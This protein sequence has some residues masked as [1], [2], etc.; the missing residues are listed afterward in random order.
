MANNHEASILIVDDQS[1]NLDVMMS[2]LGESGSNYRFL[3]ANN[4]KIACIVAEKRLPDLII[5]DW[6]MPVMNGYDALIALKNN[7]STSDIP[8]IM[9]T[10]RTTVSDL[11][12]ALSAGAVDYIRKPIEKQELLA[13]VRTCLRISNF[14][15][16][17]K[18]KNKKLEDLNREKDGIIRV[19]A[20]DLKTPLNNIKALVDLINLTGEP[21]E[22]HEKY[23]A[24]ID[25][26]TLE[27]SCMINDLLDVHLYEYGGSKLSISE[28]EIKN[29]IEDWCENFT[30]EFKRKEQHVHLKI[31]PENIKINTDKILL[32][33]ILN[34]V[35]SNAI[36]FSPKGKKIYIKVFKN[37]NTVDFSVKDEGPGISDVDQK[38]MFKMFQQLSARPTDGESSNGLGLSIIKTLVQK[39]EGQ[40]EVNSKLGSGTK[41]TIKLPLT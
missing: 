17:I 33:R 15:K 2:H 30:Q 11:N 31:E 32:S 6:E 22:K 38:K 14:I 9:A 13:R 8:V 36:K 41:F 16:E 40:I 35:L 37:T 34:N 5:M 4:G 23:L 3:Q 25:K 7:P 26:I 12:K 27:G 39:L 29:F 21:N 10:G 24:L 20:H 18:D 28:I 19:V 1:E